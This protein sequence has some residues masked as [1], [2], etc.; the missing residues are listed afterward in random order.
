MKV[1][2]KNTSQRFAAPAALSLDVRNFRPV[3]EATIDID[4]ITVLSGINACGK[5]S[6]AQL[7]HALVNFNADYEQEVRRF[8]TAKIQTITNMFLDMFKNIPKFI[9]HPTLLSSSTSIEVS[10]KEALYWV[11]SILQGWDDISEDASYTRLVRV[12]LRDLDYPGSNASKNELMTFIRKKFED[13][14]KEYGQLLQR[15]T[16]FPFQQHR[17]FP[18]LFGRND[19]ATV[20][21]L[22]YGDLVYHSEESQA[23]KID[24]VETMRDLM[25]VKRA[26]YI[27]SPLVNTPAIRDGKLDV[28]DGFPIGLGSPKD[29]DDILF[30]ILHGKMS[31]S[32]AGGILE[33]FYE[34]D[35]GHSP[36]DWRTLA[37][38]IKSVAILNVLFTKGCLDNRTLLIIDEPEVHLH[39]QW[40]FEYARIL[41]LIAKNLKVR[42]LVA[43]HSPE[44]IESLKAIVEAERIDGM[45]FYIADDAG[46]VSPY[47]YH[48][49]NLG[50]N[51]EPIFKKFNVAL[52]R[53]DTYEPTA[54]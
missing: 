11:E 53:M 32:E 35:D 4:S 26:I 48:F 3:A 2:N 49:R 37:T 7:L 40:I 22:E 17:S 51:I 24:V 29:T 31:F 30:K 10:A 25:G 23:G 16:L 18:A 39:P 36:F 50:M 28:G 12:F 9:T 47:Q 38:G 41:A 27:T 42:I 46:G 14:V 34:R 52:D 1:M 44:M 43:T 5:S 33:C 19:G 8:E 45:R 13:I 20:R 54:L 15:R 6:I 21:L